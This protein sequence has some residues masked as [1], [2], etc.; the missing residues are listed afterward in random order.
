MAVDRLYALVKSDPEQAWPEVLT[1]VRTYPD[2]AASQDL[3]EDLVYEHDERFLDR[4]EAAA[5]DDPVIRSI[6]EQLYVGG[7]ATEGAERFNRLQERLRLGQD[8]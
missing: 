7:V 8:P 4:I 3:L 5:L 2:S 1:F 6:V